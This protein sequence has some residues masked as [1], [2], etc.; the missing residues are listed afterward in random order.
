MELF[1]P[2]TDWPSEEQSENA[3]NVNKFNIENF[4]VAQSKFHYLYFEWYTENKNK[5]SEFVS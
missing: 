4:F 3:S 1:L 5:V 2:V